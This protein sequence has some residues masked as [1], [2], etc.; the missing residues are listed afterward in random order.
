MKV[1]LYRVQSCFSFGVD[2]LGRFDRRKMSL[3]INLCNDIIFNK[4]NPKNTVLAR[5]RRLKKA[6]EVPMTE[7]YLSFYASALPLFTHYSLSRQ[8]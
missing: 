3:N 4:E 7:F 1:L 2:S 5:S 8:K 6:C